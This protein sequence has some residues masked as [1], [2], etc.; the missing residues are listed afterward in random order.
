MGLVLFL[1]AAELTGGERWITL[2]PNG[3]DEKGTPVLI[4]PNPDGSAHVIGGAGGS[5]SYLK[6]KKVRSES[7]YQKE[8]EE[9]R[10]KK[11]AE[12][13]EQT[14]ADKAAGIHESKQQA[15]ANVR[16]QRLT[17]ESDFVKTVAEKL[18]WDKSVT[19]FPEAEHAGLSEPAVNKL[20]EKFHRG[21]LQQAREAV[22]QVRQHLLKDADARMTAGLSA[23]PV[24]ATSPD[25]VSVQDLDPIPTNTAGLGFST[26]YTERAEKAGQTA[27]EVDE[28]KA[29]RQSKMSDRQRE[30]IIK[31]GKLSE[32][33]GKE[34]EAVRDPVPDIKSNMGDLSKAMDLLK[35]EKKLKQVHKKSRDAMAEIND[36]KAEPKAYVLA[37]D[38]EASDDSVKEDLSNDLRTIKTRAFLSEF[39]SIGG[40]DSLG[41]FVGI[42]AFNSVNALALAVSGDALVDR[43]VVDVLGIAGAAQVLARRIHA[44]FS[45]A[46]ANRIAEGMQDFHLNEYM[47]TSQE[48]ME[49]VAALTDQA[50]AMEVTD[51][52]TATD[53]KAAQELNARHAELIHDAQRTIGEALGEMEANAALTLALKRQNDKP[54]QVSMGKVPFETA[55]TQ[56]RAI[57]LV[58]GDYQIETTAG[59]TFLTVTPEGMSRLAKPVNKADIEQVHRNLSI[60]HGDQDEDDWL[61]EGFARRP[62]LV[63]SVKPGVADRL[64]QPFA[65]GD[66]L[67]QS[68]RD[69]IGGRAADGDNPADILA[70]IQSADFVNKA[71]P[72]RAEA[73]REALDAVAPLHGKDDQMLR[74]A[75]MA[76][77]FDKY[78]DEFVDRHHKGERSGINRQQFAVDQKAGDALHRALAATP[79]GISAYKPIGE[80]EQSDQ[81]AL[82]QFFAEHVAK[83]S[84]ETLAL[85]TD[86]EEHSKKE[87]ERKVED[88]FGDSTDNPDWVDWNNRREEMSSKVNSGSL[89]WDKYIEAMRSPEKAYESM[90]DLVRSHVNA[91][92]AKTYN[93][94]NPGAPI[95]TGRAPIRNNL[96]HLDMIDPEA[97]AKRQEADRQRIDALRERAAGRY[98]SGSVSDKLDAARAQ[99]DAFNQSQMGFFS[100]EESPATAEK[101]LGGDERHTLGHI[102]ERQI[103]GMMGVYGRNFDAK[104]PTKIFQPSMSGGKNAPRQRLIKMMEANK[105]VVAAFGTGSGKT[106]ISLGAYS[107]LQSKG[108][109]KRGLFLVPSIVQGQFGGAALQ[110]LEPGKYNWHIKPG[111][112]RDER[113]SAYKDP[114]YHFAAMTHAAFTADM[115]HLGAKAEGIPEADMRDRV[116]AMDA[117]DRCAWMHGLMEREGI[118]FDFLNV[119][120]GQST[121][122]RQ[123]K[124]N[125]SL[126]NVVDSVSANTPYYMSASADPVKNDTSEIYDIMSKM[127]PERY[128]DRDAF[129]RR[130]GADTVGSKDALRREMARYLYP[131]KIDPDVKV[132]RQEKRTELSEGQKLSLKE[133]DSHLGAMSLARMEGRVDVDAARSVSPASFEGA[134]EAEHENIA[135][136]LQ[137]NTGILKSSAIQRVI[138]THEDNPGA[139]DVVKTAA[140]RQGKPGIVFAHSLAAVKLLSGRLETAGHKVITITGA[141]SA[142]DKERKRSEFQQG[143]S[144]LVASDAAAV[145]M[146]AQKGQW[147]YQYDTPHTAMLHAQRG[148]RIYRTGQK[149]DVE[150]MDN[151]PNHPEIHK[152]RD[153]LTKKYAL[154]ELMTT[155][156]DA[157]DESGIAY[158]LKQRDIASG[159]PMGS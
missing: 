122:N 55:L 13:K 3:P 141:D 84:P 38:D 110:F 135:K 153:R 12:R 93:T 96:A 16:V 134:P 21:V 139:D 92:F 73:Y 145:G 66:D 100:S 69:Y 54:F 156:L 71:G 120:E 128:R 108:K 33:I 22:V 31:R 2:H 58:R 45:A 9:K 51:L 79:A 63:M 23:V 105:R 118:N 106:A 109:V 123:G 78:A 111:A 158:Y 154:R 48:A 27:E 147:A 40:G 46:Q 146:N 150:L 112:S 19:E 10:Q 144:I 44:D 14:K 64:A 98:A 102:A 7:E 53:I 133:L 90:Q 1:K 80:L 117:R 125:S 36:A 28:Q 157:M 74:A 25:V 52:S 76:P 130:Y 119:D 43:S 87:P 50:K 32:A 97:R 86:M 127:D 24:T 143:G 116:N 115:L 82:R 68:L 15:K 62:D 67:G 65:G 94:L 29:E 42:G 126:A 107:H 41:K 30:S 77:A 39:H 11:T 70:D 18:G 60:I 149:N 56:A 17:H 142:A 81:R 91:S 124:A 5:L 88:M 59:N 114:Q 49:R 104:Q 148:A 47:A 151:V 6:L 136:G 85:R 20:R 72:G 37:A 155:P 89:T 101:P 113:I 95:K 152:A 129:M 159:K 4:R 75:D 99:E 83:D 140:D 26:K 137:K 121:L 57:G 34:L 138:N 61:P 35:A 103:A 8:A 131:S 132:D